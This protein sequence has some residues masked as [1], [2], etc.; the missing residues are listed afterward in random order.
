M[1]S[2]KKNKALLIIVGAILL[3]A[4][5]FGGSKYLFSAPTKAGD[6]TP[7]FIGQA[8]EFSYLVTHDLS[9][10]VNKVV[11][12]TGQVSEVT[13]DGILINGTIYCQFDNPVKLKTIAKNQSLTIKGKMV[14]FDEL[15]M[16]I[17]LSQC[18][19]P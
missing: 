3:T 14:G 17:K 10:W 13:E 18:I 11:Q 19:I 2:S 16:E 15:L 4:I 7:E 12:L 6:T 5:V 1:N 8:Q 9:F